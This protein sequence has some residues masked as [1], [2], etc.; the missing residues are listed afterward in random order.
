M[1]ASPLGAMPEN[2]GGG[3]GA[4]PWQ[5][6]SPSSR[7]VF[8]GAWDGFRVRGSPCFQRKGLGLP[9]G[10]SQGLAL[11]PNPR[12]PISAQDASFPRS[13]GNSETSTKMKPNSQDSPQMWF[14]PCGT[15]NQNVD[16]RAF[17]PN[18]SVVCR[19]RLVSI[20]V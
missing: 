8:W 14:F 3:E 2:T 10:A 6:R 18:R 7:Q 5:F 12:D 15:Y 11:N 1:T 4:S 9:R 17:L 13:K 20:A 16:K 19:P